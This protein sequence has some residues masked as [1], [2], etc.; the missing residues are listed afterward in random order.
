MAE[1]TKNFSKQHNLDNI[2]QDLFRRAFN[3]KT[4]Y[5][6]NY[7][8]DE[9]YK[10]SGNEP[11]NKQLAELRKD[12]SRFQALFEHLK[13]RNSP[14]QPE[15]VSNDDKLFEE[16][17]K[18]H[19]LRRHRLEMVAFSYMA[20]SENPLM[21]IANYIY[22]QPDSKIIIRRE[23]EDLEKRHNIYKQLIQTMMIKDGAMS[24]KELEEFSTSTVKKEIAEKTC[25]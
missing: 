5:P 16:Y 19:D 10:M 18:K 6:L 25:K 1:E 24:L 12:V 20:E 9:I 3:A 22:K 14:A 2:L 13:Q 23:I 8:A 21:F 15:T 17:Y 7:I 4:K 11:E